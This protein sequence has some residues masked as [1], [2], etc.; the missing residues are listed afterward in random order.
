MESNV[1][2]KEGEGNTSNSLHRENTISPR[3]IDIGD[4]GEDSCKQK[5]R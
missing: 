4:I 3:S 5:I 2:E 1:N